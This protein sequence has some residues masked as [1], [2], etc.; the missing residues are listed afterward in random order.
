[1][2][3]F[4][5][6][7]RRIGIATPV[8]K[9]VLLLTDVEGQEEISQL[10]CYKVKMIS[11]DPAIDP[12]KIVG[13]HVAIAMMDSDDQPR[14][15]NGIVRRFVNQG[16]GDQG[17]IYTAEIVPWLWLL[18]RNSDCRI[19]QD[20]TVPQIIEQVL[21]GLNFNDFD[22][23]GLNGQYPKLDY[24]VQYQET[25]FQFLCRLMEHEG[26]YYYFSHNQTKH[27]LM[28]G[29]HAGA[30]E[31]CKD[32]QVRF[33]GSLGF[34]D[35]G[36]QIVSW[37]HRYEFCS[38]RVAAKDFNFESPSQPMLSKDQTVVQY[39]RISDFEL[40]EYPGGF[41]DRSKGDGR[42]RLRMQEEEMVHD[43][44]HGTSKCR[45]FSPGYKFSVTEHNNPQEEGKAFVLT[46][47][48]HK[49]AAGSY[50]TGGKKPEGYK[51]T[52]RCV[53]ASVVC[54]PRRATPRPRIRGPQSAVV[55]GPQGQEIYTDQHGRV[56]VQFHWDR[57]GKYDENSSCWIRVAQNMA[58]KKWGAINI[59]RIGH[60]VIVEFMEGDPDRP[61]VTGRVYNGETIP[62]YDLPKH[63]TMSTFK[64]NS[65]KGGQGFNEI[66]FEDKKDGEQVF[67]HAQRDMDIRVRN[68]RREIIENNRHLIV[69][70][71]K[72]EHIEHNR[73]EQVDADHMEK[74]GKDRHLCVD[75]KEAV[76]ISGSKSLTVKG[77]VLEVFQAD[78]SEQVT[79]DYYVKGTNLVIEG[80]SNVTIKVG[81][82]YIAIENGGIKLGTLGQIEIE[83]TGQTT[84]KGTAGVAIES[85]L[86]TTVK[87][88]A[89][90]KLESTVMTELSGTT[91]TVKGNAMTTIQGA[92]VR[93]N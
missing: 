17:S 42:V 37:E 31:D 86:Q 16:R 67:V 25:D 43:V 53:P 54:R 14:Y 58:G 4:T 83:S 90:L 74:I 2:A 9:D 7:R 63:A 34:E 73:N 40:Y 56:K 61:I 1:M 70:T 51:N 33:T 84:V 80:M 35:V 32:S 15:V 72:H 59:P 85:P 26:I 11:E 50:V 62:P 92:L 81:Q 12:Q 46:S 77:D 49:A 75:G 65:S 55:V 79:G 66:R 19:F 36:N 38:G 68:D 30:Y 21:K 29:D 6:E 20:M 89:S 52:F 76:E 78:H 64:T 10:F 22:L 41:D 44:V 13:H 45:S 69:K 5:Q 8:G 48:E 3:S 28:L 87:G 82:S 57:Y 39:Q 18:T 24:C 60:E 27:V 88:T 91:T 23:S 71:D 93:I 47:V